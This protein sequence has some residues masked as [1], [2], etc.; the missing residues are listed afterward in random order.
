[1][2]NIEQNEEYEDE[3]IR[4]VTSNSDT[5]SQ[6]VIFEN[7]H[8]NLFAINVAK[9]EEL[10]RNRDLTLSE[11]TLHDDVIMG[12][13]KIRDNFVTLIDFD[14]WLGHKR[15]KHKEQKLIILCN[16]SNRRIG[17][18][19]KNVVGI[20]SIDAIDM[21]EA[22]DKDDKIAFIAEMNLG[23]TVLCNIFDSD[24]LIFDI[25]PNIK[26]DN[27][28]KVEHEI[29]EEN[30]TGKLLL[31]AEDSKLI[32]M[33]VKKLLDKRG[34]HYEMFDNGQLLYDRLI[35]LEPEKVGM[36]ITDIEMPVMDGMELLRLVKSNSIY[37]GIPVIVNTNMANSAV[38]KASTQ[39][40]ALDVTKKLDL[41]GLDHSIERFTR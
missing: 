8:D 21:H 25:F 37:E 15:S 27:E 24:R 20:Q 4:L 13:A 3:L 26:I 39:L 17:L 41:E 38:I 35:T 30:V 5:S 7:I 16:Y 29:S 10:I 9:V 31:L 40:G 32:Q 2:I 14:Q 12:M 19:V 36:I 23:K 11:T 33:S 18:A 6:Y 28:D 34:Y 22:S 1:M